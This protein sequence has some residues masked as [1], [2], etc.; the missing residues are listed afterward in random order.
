MSMP[1]AKK[2]VR[3]ELTQAQK[4]ALQAQTGKNADAIELTIQ[5]LEPRIAPRLAAN[6]TETLLADD[7]R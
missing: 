7:A 2:V 1:N 3:I 5:E 6:H 4:D